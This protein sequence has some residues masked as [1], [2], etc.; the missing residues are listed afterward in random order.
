MS[1]FGHY[2][3]FKNNLTNVP[4]K[5]T[6]INMIFIETSLF[7]NLIPEYFDDDDDYTEL[8][9]FLVKQPK[10]GAVIPGAGGLRKLR[11]SSGNKGKRGGLRIIYY[12]KISED[13]IYLMTVFSK[14][15]AAD[16]TIEEKKLLKKMVEEW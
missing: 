10:A 12:F 4:F 1:I 11:W 6:L 13:Q 8:Q 15:E 5:G 3:D 9:L 2:L 7:T 16:L 14:N